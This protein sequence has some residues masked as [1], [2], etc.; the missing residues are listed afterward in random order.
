MVNWEEEYKALKKQH[1]ALKDIQELQ[2][3]S[4]FREQLLLNL[5]KISKSLESQDTALLTLNK[6]CEECGT[7]KNTYLRKGI[8]VCRSCGHSSQ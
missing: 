5:K 4:Y 1:E 7:T 6:M 3:D 2:Q 8:L